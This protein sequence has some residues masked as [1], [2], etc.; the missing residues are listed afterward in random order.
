M[1]MKLKTFVIGV[2]LLLLITSIPNGSVMFAHSSPILNESGNIVEGA[3]KGDIHPPVTTIDFGEPYYANIYITSDTPIYLNATDNESGVNVTYYKINDGKW[4]EYIASFSIPDDCEH[5]IYFYSV[6]YAG[7]E[8]NV[9]NKNVSVDNYPPFPIIPL[10]GGENGW[11]N[12]GV[13][14]MF[15][16]AE[17]KSGISYIMFR[18]DNGDWMVYEGP[19]IIRSDGYHTVDYY[20]VD[21]VGNE[22]TGSFS[23]KIDQTPPTITIS[24]EQI[25]STKWTAIADVS[26]ETSGVER[27]EFYLDDKLEGTD[28]EAP[29]EL[30]LPVIGSG[31]VVQAI[32]YDNAGNYCISCPSPPVPPTRVFG[33][34]RNPEFTE[35]TVS[36][37]AIVVVSNNCPICIRRQLTFQNDYSGYIGEHFIFAVFKYGP[38]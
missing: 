10:P 33:I 2:A 20:A 16:D 24:F 11:Y 28:T 22:G 3:G 6:D 5:A 1:D 37:F 14:I 32:V 31:H 7:N 15:I 36:F 8:E 29:F 12:S 19:F 26:D 9:K 18:V 17:E 30:E 13:I 34:I 21:N 25:D 23:I 27:V 35:E 4:E 38:V